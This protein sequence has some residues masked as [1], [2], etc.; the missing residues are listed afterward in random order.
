M[1]K[2]CFLILFLTCTLISINAQEKKVTSPDGK[3]IVTV[4]AESGKPIYSILYNGKIFLEKSP[5]GLKTNVGDFS[6]GLVMDPAN[7]TTNIDETYELPDIKYSK[8]QYKAVES[9]STFSKGNKKAI[10]IVFRVSNNDVAIKY[11]VYPQ[12]ANLSCVVNEEVTGFTL[13]AGTTT[14]ICP[15]M[16]PMGGFARTSPSYETSYVADGPMG[17]NGRGEGYSFPC[18][19]REGNNGWLLISENW[20]VAAIAEAA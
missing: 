7:V 18:L 9:I 10:D 16:K 13:P 20:V 12:G 5:L 6:E 17:E 1:R 19:F 2:K 8:V 14:F 4:S 15:Q 11:K 3:L